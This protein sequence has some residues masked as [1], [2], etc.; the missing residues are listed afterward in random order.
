[1]WLTRVSIVRPIF[2][3]MVITALVIM[4]GVSFARLNA[5]LFPNVNFPVVAVTTVY[6]G[7]SPDDVERLISTPIEEAVSGIANVDYVQATSQEGRS[8]IVVGFTDKA[9]SDTAATDVERKVSA[10]RGQLPTDANPPSIL[11]FDPGQ[12]AVLNIALSGNRS[13]GDLH[14]W[15]KNTLK[16]QLE[17]LGGVGS[18]TISGGLEREIQVQVDP[19]RLR[20]YNMTIEQVSAALA[21]ENQGVPGGSLDRGKQQ[22]NVRL[23]SLF[24]SVDEIEGVV[25]GS[26]SAGPLYLRNV[27]K[28][29]DTYK[30]P[31]TISKLN[32]QNA[33]AIA[34]TKQS[35]ANEIETVNNVRTELK[36]LQ[37]T[38]PEG[39]KLEVIADNSTFTRNSLA[40]VQRSLIEAIVL[41]GLVLL[42]FLHTLR[43]TTIVLFA[44]P[45]SL[46]STFL[47]LNFMGFTLNLMTTLALVL[48]IGVLVDDSIV[49]LEN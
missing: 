7:A 29:V 38:L 20:A 28:V 34:I 19:D 13:L 12:Q 6:S 21:R 10:I 2:M 35:S 26:T 18:V 39:V 37:E 48:V 40:G 42:V 44:I 46:I 15:A 14:S 43:S 47:F 33:V 31:T 5:E 17:K 24:Q 11:K 3:L 45:T 9:N 49:V 22:I 1:M 4:G 8:L 32:G 27:A 36:R 41:T 16:P 23:S 30:K 25:V